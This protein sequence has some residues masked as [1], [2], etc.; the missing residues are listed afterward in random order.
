[1]GEYRTML[2][3]TEI[4]RI[5]DN[6]YWS[7]FNRGNEGN[8]SLGQ[9]V[10]HGRTVLEYRMIIENKFRINIEIGIY[11]LWRI[12]QYLELVIDHIFQ[13]H[14][15]C[16]II[17]TYLISEDKWGVHILKRKGFEKVVSRRSACKIRGKYLDIETWI[18]RKK[19]ENER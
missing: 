5:S 18:Y 10:S 1:M 7:N 16:K 4:E 2:E 11:S 13:T 15:E 19:G 12:S 9:L 14:T 3:F 6:Y 17:S 8:F